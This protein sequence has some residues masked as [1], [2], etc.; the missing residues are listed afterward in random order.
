MTGFVLLLIAAALAFGLSKWMR[1][2]VIP[3][4][5]LA[6]VGLGGRGAGMGGNAG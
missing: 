1:L 2:P 5:I 4:L 6:G 3:L